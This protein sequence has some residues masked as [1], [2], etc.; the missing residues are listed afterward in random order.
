M[1]HPV[2]AFFAIGIGVLAASAGPLAQATAPTKPGTSTAAAAKATA[3]HILLSAD[4][5]K[6]G[7]AP[8]GLPGGAQLAVLDGDPS[9]AGVPYALAAKFPDG[10]TIP[11]H[12]HPT[13][14]NV[15]VFSGTLMVGMGKTLDESS[16]KALGMGGYA[17]LPRRM[18]HWAKAKGETII[19]VYGMGPFEIT[20][21][22]P[23]DDPRK[24][25]TQ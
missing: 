24:T 1:R 23:K 21:V 17:K 2:P 8:P 5:L 9:K 10:Y 25:G 20:Y 11:P 22:N 14:E 6:W 13:D 16:G 12:W 19:H 3:Q 18:P 4:E 15:Q 7:P